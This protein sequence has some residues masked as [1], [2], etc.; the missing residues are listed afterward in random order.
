MPIICLR[1][2]M[3]GESNEVDGTNCLDSSSQKLINQTF[4]NEEIA[5]TALNES[6]H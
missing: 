1:G 5:S 2:K 4:L 3:K 6:H